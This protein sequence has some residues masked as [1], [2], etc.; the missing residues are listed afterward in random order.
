MNR[1][2]L[3]LGMMVAYWRE[4]EPGSQKRLLMAVGVAAG[5]R[6]HPELRPLVEGS[7]DAGEAAEL[8]GVGSEDARML[9]GARI[10]L[11]RA[12]GSV[13]PARN[14]FAPEL[15][16]AA[17]LLKRDPGPWGPEAAN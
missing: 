4:A 5:I 1:A 13:D 10:E 17:E 3:G 12:D 11:V 6:K 15:A 16:E 7:L 2:A 14:P 9:R 8:A